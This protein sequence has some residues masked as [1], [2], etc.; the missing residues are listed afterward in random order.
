MDKHNFDDEAIQK[1]A[2]LHGKIET[3]PKVKVLTEEDLS[4]YYTPGVGAVSKLLAN[5]PEKAKDYT[6]KSNTIAVISDGSAVLGLGNVGPEA[7]MPVMEGK[8]MLLKSLAGVDAFPIC[9]DTQ[10]TEEIILTIKNI[11]P[12]F[13]GINLEDISSPKCFEIERRLQDEL[14]IP[15]IHDDQH[16]TAIVVLAGLINALKV[17]DK[18]ATTSRVVILGAGAAGVGVAILLAEYGFE[19][20]I[21]VDSKGII[22]S[23]RTDLNSEKQALAKLVN[24]RDVQGDLKDALENSDVF[25]GLSSG[26]NLP[27]ELIKTMNPKSIIF[28]LANPEP[29]ILPSQ[30]LEAGAMVV[31]SGRSDFPNQINN[32]LV[33]P[34]LFKGLIDNKIVEV[35]SKVKIEA[36]KA[37]AS[38]VESPTP[39]K[40][41]PSV[42]DPAVVEAIAKSIT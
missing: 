16:A 13:A 23:A 17:V 9:L 5:N 32:V 20:I 25:I 22:S 4:I 3:N 2:M 6:I 34:G 8:A 18:P 39:E 29:E 33:F 12:V 28:A 38:V 11:A 36:A 27:P 41:I 15:V 30:A 26:G 40:I 35:S 31:A 14:D 24:K 37:L 21:V 10:D 42:F 19:D 1:H 7:A